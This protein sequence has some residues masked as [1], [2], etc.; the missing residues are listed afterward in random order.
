MYQFVWLSSSKSHVIR[1]QG[2]KCPTAL[3]QERIELCGKLQN[4]CLAICVL[5]FIFLASKGS[6]KTMIENYWYEL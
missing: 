5:F 4:L 2:P 6:E 3:V 1:F